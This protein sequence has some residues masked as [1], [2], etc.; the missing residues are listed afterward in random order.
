MVKKK[1]VC[2]NSKLSNRAKC[3]LKPVTQKSCLTR[4]QSAARKEGVMKEVWGR[5]GKLERQCLSVLVWYLGGVRKRG[6]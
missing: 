4:V 5:G 6:S 1:K 3:D 2:G